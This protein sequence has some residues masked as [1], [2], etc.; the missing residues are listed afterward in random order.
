MTFG[1]LIG[2]VVCGAAFI[3][4]MLLKVLPV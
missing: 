3:M 2:S 4:D 1:I